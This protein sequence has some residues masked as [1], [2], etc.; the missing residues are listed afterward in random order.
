MNYVSLDSILSTYVGVDP[1]VY[2]EA[3]LKLSTMSS[4]GVNS[5]ADLLC[6]EIGGTP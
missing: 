3:V 5:V 4:A 2:R 6:R 1:T